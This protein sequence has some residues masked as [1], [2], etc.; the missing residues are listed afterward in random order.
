MAK[1]MVNILLSEKE[2]FHGI[3]I[4]KVRDLVHEQ[5]LSC[6]KH[7]EK[8]T[9]YKGGTYLSSDKYDGC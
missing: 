5:R 7:L 9:S 6:V 3:K 1:M 8:V 2:S 4:P